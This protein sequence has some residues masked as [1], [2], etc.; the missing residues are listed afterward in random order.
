MTPDQVALAGHA[1]TATATLGTALI[2]SKALAG[3]V[4]GAM[5]FLG[6]ICMPA[7]GAI[8]LLLEDK[9]NTYRSSNLV[10]LL[11]TAQSKMEQQGINLDEN[12][13][14][15]RI[16]HEVLEKAS[17]SDDELVQELWAGLL[18][19]SC[20]PDGKDE[21]NLIFTILLGQLTSLQAKILRYACERS[22]KAAPAGWVYARQFVVDEHEIRLVTASDDFHRIDRELD[23]LRALGLLSENSGF[24]TH[25]TA[26]V[27][28]LTPTPLCLQLFMR[29]QGYRG[30]PMAYFKMPSQPMQSPVVQ[31]A[32]SQDAA[33]P[34]SVE[35]T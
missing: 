16:V 34:N 24:N 9:I 25:L 10:A 3:T 26:K 6:K 23:H 22:E 19:S 11:T 13:A 12:H 20:T 28:E 30:E 32:S 7:A 2:A 17:W 8:G 1:L 27:A 33:S 31:E 14:H 5:N 21:S 18:A 4:K 35:P 15:P 29:C